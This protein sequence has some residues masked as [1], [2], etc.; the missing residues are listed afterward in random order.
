MESKIVLMNLFTVKQCRCR[1]REQTGGHSEEGEGRTNL[2]SSIDI[3]TLSC[4]K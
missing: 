3:Y 2:E 1:H 4:V